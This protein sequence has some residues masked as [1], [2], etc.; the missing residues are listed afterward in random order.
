MTV[1]Q[2]FDPWR[3]LAEHRASETFA[4]SRS[5]LAE[6]KTSKSQYVSAAYR[7]FSSSRS[8]RREQAEKPEPC[9]E[10]AIYTR[11]KVLTRSS[12]SCNYKD[13]DDCAGG[14]ARVARDA[15]AQ[16]NQDLALARSARAHCESCESFVLSDEDLAA[17]FDERAAILEYDGGYP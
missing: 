6:H 10:P 8:S 1:R 12:P 7:N 17:L 4:N 13:D 9:R 14:P 5:T 15:K 2:P 11:D 3:V 16:A